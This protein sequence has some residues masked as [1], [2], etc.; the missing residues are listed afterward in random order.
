MDP[1]SVHSC[2]PA[3]GGLG[4]DDT[5]NTPNLP[6]PEPYLDTVRV[7]RGA[8]QDILDDTPGHF[9]A[10]LILLEDDIN[11]AA[12]ADSVAARSVRPGITWLIHEN[13]DS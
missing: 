9:S 6:V 7:C 4:T 11:H 13:Q 1:C 3:T 2:V 12:G 5:G 10:P 8:G